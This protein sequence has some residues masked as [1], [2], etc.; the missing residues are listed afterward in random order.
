MPYYLNVENGKI[1][2]ASN[3]RKDSSTVKS[4][5]VPETLYYDY[6]AHEDKY[7]Y[8]KTTDLIVVDQEW[9]DAQVAIREQGFKKE[10]FETSLGWIRRKPTLADGT[11][12][13]FL[14]NDLPLF[15]IALQSNTPVV[16]PVAYGL[17]DFTNELTDEYM[18]SLQI[19]NQPV[20]PQFIA[21]CLQVK[22]RDFSGPT[23]EPEQEP[24]VEEEVEEQPA[25]EEDEGSTDTEE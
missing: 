3:Q 1:I 12:D 15:A 14:N 20:T 24:A 17:P 25:E 5:S 22:I 7:K 9:V 11:K 2:N 16:L 4:Y 8:D 23:E 21:E 13:D 6:L 18:I 10:F 19:L